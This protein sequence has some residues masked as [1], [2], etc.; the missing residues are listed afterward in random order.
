MLSYRHAFHAGNHGDVLKHTILAKILA[1]LIQKDSPFMY[2]DTH[3]GAG[4]YD[5][6][7]YMALKTNDKATGIARIWRESSLP[8]LLQPYFNVLHKYNSNEKLSLYPGSPLIAQYFMR[9]QDHGVCY[10]L[11][12][13]DYTTLSN[14]LVHDHKFNVIQ[15]DG[16]KALMSQLPPKERRALILIDPSYEQISEYDSVL[17]AIEKAMKRFPTGIYVIWYPLLSNQYAKPLLRGLN[18]LSIPKTLHIE[19]TVSNVNLSMGLIGS[20]LWIINP[21]WIL[22]AELR[23]SLPWLIKKLGEF[24]ARYEINSPR[25]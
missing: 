17:L 13:A 3:A 7:R 9:S 25:M 16:F 22:E 12:P 5:L 8:F 19:F 15:K 14:L 24:D 18:A 4:Q 2:L 20:G 11:H 21:P 23:E 6:N 10:E 1:Y